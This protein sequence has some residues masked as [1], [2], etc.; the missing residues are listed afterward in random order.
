MGQSDLHHGRQEL[1]AEE[2]DGPVGGVAGQ[3]G[4]MQRDTVFR[5]VPVRTGG[6]RPGSPLP[7]PQCRPLSPLRASLIP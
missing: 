7:R 5:V 6:V 3:N 1:C 2:A 4:G